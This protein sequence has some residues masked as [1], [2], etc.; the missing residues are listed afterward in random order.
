MFYLLSFLFFVVS[1]LLLSLG[2]F[3]MN[4]TS[5]VLD[6]FI[7][8][9]SLADFHLSF[10]FD[11]LAC[12][13]FSFVSLISSIV[14]LYSSFYMSI[15]ANSMNSDNN[16]FLLI[17]ML[18]V[19][20]M[21]FLV[22]SNSWI[23]VMLGWDGLG[24]I[25][26]L[27]VIYYNDASSLNSGLVTVFTNRVGDCFFIMSFMFMLSNGWMNMDFISQ[28]CSL[29]FSLI[30]GMGCITKSAQ[31]PFS[32]WLPAAMAA[33]TPVS[34]LVHS[35]TLVTAGIYLMVRF[36]YL[37][38][39][40]FYFLSFISLFTMFLAGVCSM[41]ELDFK[42][43]VAMSTLSQLGFMM[44]S[45]STGNWLLCFLHMSFHAFFKSMLF[46]S[47]GS[48]MHMILGDQD[49]RKFGSMGDS[50]VSKVFFNMSCM[51]LIGFPFTLGFYSKD[52]ILGVLFFYDFSVSAAIFFLCCCLTVSYSIRLIFMGFTGNPSF[53]SSMEF[54]ENPMFFLPVV[55]LF[56][57]CSFMGPSF[58]FYFLPVPVFTFFD[59]FVG[60]LV[61]MGGILTFNFF[62]T[63]FFMMVNITN[64]GFISI[65]SSSKMSSLVMSVSSYKSEKSWAELLGAS[66]VS[67]W[68]NSFYKVYFSLYAVK[69][70]T[71][72]MFMVLI[73]MINI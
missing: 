10:N 14:F 28:G 62:K 55:I 38:F 64:M 26:F 53:L 71:L 50:L 19:L 20:S 18:F 51:S 49:S 8:F 66:G 25:S 4:Y 61:L 27:L 16:R 44:F 9:S 73:L 42:K 6:L 32:S 43:V 45:L 31:M 47:T 15:K 17:L 72:P 3:S 40:F 69:F 46:L 59:L 22:F 2:V 13:F 60:I 68:L 39:D 54:S 63:N 57:C 65:L 21:M 67:V 29:L 41:V 37:L 52:A 12:F 23:S 11:Y 7:T 35:S 56:F 58:M 48:L 24:L 30:L 34:S 5:Y 36:N 33:P 1:L 70:F